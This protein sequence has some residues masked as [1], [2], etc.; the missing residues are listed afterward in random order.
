MKSQTLKALIPLVAI[1]LAAALLLG[2]FNLITEK[3]IQENSLRTAMETRRR[4][5]PKAANF[6]ETTVEP[7]S[8]IDS[9]YLGVDEQGS[10]VGY[11]AAAHGE[12]LRR[13]SGGDLGMNLSGRLTGLDVGGDNFSET[14]GL[15][16]LAKEPAFTGQYVEKTLPLTLVKAPAQADADSVEAISG[17]TRTST[18]VNDGVNHIGAY[19]LRLMESSQL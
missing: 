3:P 6:E 18:A 8:G 12:R 16:A 5:M 11:V 2:V 14:A 4:L 15:G 7:G 17:A 19:L 1:C 9:C 13:R 10:P